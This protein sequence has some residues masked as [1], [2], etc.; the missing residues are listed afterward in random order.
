MQ[1]W[2][3]GGAVALAL[4]LGLGLNVTTVAA[5]TPLPM[6]KMTP[7]VV[8]SD[9]HTDYQLVATHPGLL[10]VALLGNGTDDLFLELQDDEGQRVPEGF[11]DNDRLGHA[12]REQL[13]LLVPWPGTYRLRVGAHGSSSGYEIGATYLETPAL[14][15]PADP[16]GRPSKA[17]VLT[18]GQSI[19]D[20]VGAG[21]GDYWDWFVVKP[22]KGGTLTVTTTGDEGD[23]VL[24]AYLDGSFAGPQERADDDRNGKGTNEVLLLEVTAG[25][26][27][28]VRVV[29]VFSSSDA[30]PY[31]ISA[32][33][34]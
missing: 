17:Q 10:T 16:D 12:G 5:Q 6:G 14:G 1:R 20:S 32:T 23:L 8:G 27:V 18:P 31:R 28:Y 34:Q 4:S 30:T 25:Q 29:P 3:T 22:A 9:G 7:G 15:L 2:R 11:A 26:P 19:E 33:L 24:E 13:Q 21:S